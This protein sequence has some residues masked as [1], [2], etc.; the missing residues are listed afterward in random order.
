MRIFSDFSEFKAAVGTE[1]ERAN[2]L[3]SLR[4]VST[5]LRRLPATSNGSTS[6]VR[7]LSPV[8]AGS[9]IRGRISIAEA[10]DVPPD[11]L[12]VNYRMVTRSK[13]VSAGPRRRADSTPLPLR[14]DATCHIRAR[15][16]VQRR[17]ATIR[18]GARCGLKPDMAQGPKG[19]AK[20]DGYLVRYL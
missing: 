8:P 16:V 13:E 3:R 9:R 6:S 7:Y 10:E 4:I 2:G 19:L 12:K 11:G 5:S 1:L 14:P 20:D 18:F 17:G 15:P